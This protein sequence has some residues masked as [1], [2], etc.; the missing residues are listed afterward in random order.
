[1]VRTNGTMVPTVHIVL[2]VGTVRNRP[3]C[4]VVLV[5][6]RTLHSWSAFR[7]VVTSI[8]VIFVNMSLIVHLSNSIV[9]CKAFDDT[10]K[11]IACY[12]MWPAWSVLAWSACPV[13]ANRRCVRSGIPVLALICAAVRPSSRSC[14]T[15]TRAGVWCS[16][17]SI[18][19]GLDVRVGLSWLRVCDAMAVWGAWQEAS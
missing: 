18:D 2:L 7:S 16:P 14:R 10:I 19:W 11:H 6:F 8:E 17:R 3:P 4:T 9:P 1:M 5:C 13:E 12:L 15:R